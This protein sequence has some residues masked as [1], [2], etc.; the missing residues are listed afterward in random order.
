M[1]RDEPFSAVG[2]DRRYSLDLPAARE[3]VLGTALADEL[4]NVD[5]DLI[6][7]ARDERHRREV[8]RHGLRD[9]CTARRRKKRA[10]EEQAKARTHDHIVRPGP[11]SP[12]AS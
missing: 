9:G 4:Q 3:D 5:G 10:S 12:R 6:V 2:L 11:A 1:Q 7:R 8:A